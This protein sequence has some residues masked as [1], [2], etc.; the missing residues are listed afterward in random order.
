MQRRGSQDLGAPWGVSG[1]ASR[2]DA[3]DA[4]DAVEAGAGA[5]TNRQTTHGGDGDGSQGFGTRVDDASAGAGRPTLTLS[6]TSHGVLGVNLDRSVSG[7]AGDC[8]VTIGAGSVDSPLAGD[9]L[10][11]VGRASVHR[12]VQGWAPSQ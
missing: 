3:V 2:V 1:G 11:G 5:L 9:G 8:A 4:V 10:L 6:N 7:S 12:Q